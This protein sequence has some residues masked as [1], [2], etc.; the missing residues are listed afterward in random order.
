MTRVRVE[1]RPFDQGRCKNDAFIHS[2]TL[3]MMFQ[4]KIYLQVTDDLPA[5]KNGIFD[6]LRKLC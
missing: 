1:P 2:A 4:V 5:I 6:A 3:V